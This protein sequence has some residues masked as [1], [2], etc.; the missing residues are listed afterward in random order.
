[1]SSDHWLHGLVEGTRAI[2]ERDD[3]L[4]VLVRSSDDEEGRR[5]EFSPPE[6]EAAPK[7]AERGGNLA[8]YHLG[9]G[10]EAG[11]VITAGCRSFVTARVCL[12]G[13]ASTGL[14]AG[15]QLGSR[16]GMVGKPTWVVT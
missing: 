14:C 7:G 16:G 2:A 5:L 9:S 1:M 15:E 3:P 12:S 11:G 13:S 8:A 10:A 6:L 4:T